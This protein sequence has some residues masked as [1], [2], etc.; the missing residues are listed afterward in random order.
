MMIIL[1]GSIFTSVEE[2]LYATASGFS[3]ATA[4]G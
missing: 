2:N 3:D 4:P 1:T